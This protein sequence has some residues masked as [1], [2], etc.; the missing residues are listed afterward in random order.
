MNFKIT[1]DTLTIVNVVVNSIAGTVAKT[2]I[3]VPNV[4][5]KPASKVKDTI[6]GLL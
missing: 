1:N 5:A 2:A 4:N 3:T 6:N